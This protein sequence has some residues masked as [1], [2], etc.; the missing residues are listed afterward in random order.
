MILTLDAALGPCAAGLV[1][2][3]HIVERRLDGSRGNLARLPLLVAELLDGRAAGLAFIAVTIGPGSFT[4]IRAAL[5][6]AHGIA[7]A[8]GCPVHGVTIGAALAEP[9]P[10]RAFWTVID[11]RR[12]R[13]FLERDGVVQSLALDDVPDPPGPIAVAGDAAEAVHARL[14]AR[15]CD[16]LLLPGRIPTPAGIARAARLTPWPPQPLYVDPV[17]ARLPS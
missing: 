2:G 16:T 8:A 7:L 17:A 11:S 12:G 14:L 4:G 3:E 5:A 9:T 6:L 15:G 13:V 10:G 1:E